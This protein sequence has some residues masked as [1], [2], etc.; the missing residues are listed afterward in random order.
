MFHV[1][2]IQLTRMLFLFQC[3]LPCV[4]ALCNATIPQYGLVSRYL[5]M[6]NQPVQGLV[7]LVSTCEFIVQGLEINMGYFPVWM[8]SNHSNST[9]ATVLTDPISN[10]T[11]ASGEFLSE[12]T[13]LTNVSLD[14][15]SVLLLVDQRLDII[16]G[17]VQL[18]GSDPG[19]P[20]TSLPLCY[21]LAPNYRLRWDIQGSQIDFA[22][23]GQDSPVTWMGFG[24]AAPGVTNRPMGAADA[25]IVISNPPQIID[26]YMSTYLECFEGSGACADSVTT[27]GLNEARGPGRNDST[28]VY[29]QRLGSVNFARFRR[30]LDTGDVGFDHVITP[31]ASQTFVWATGNFLNSSSG[32]K[33]LTHGTDEGTTYGSLT[34][35][36][37]SGNSNCKPFPVPPNAS[38]PVFRNTSGDGFETKFAGGAQAQLA[39]DSVTLFWKLDDVAKV[40]KFGLRCRKPSGYLSLGVGALMSG[41][42]TWVSVV[43][44]DE[45][46]TYN[47]GSQA[48][49][50]FA[51]NNERVSGYAWY[52]K[53]NIY[54]FE[55][56]RPYGE[57]DVSS[58]IPFIWAAG[59]TWHIPPAEEDYHTTRSAVPTYINLRTGTV[60]VAAGDASIVAHGVLMGLA[61]G[62]CVPIAI[63]L[64]RGARLINKHKWQMYHPY[65]NAFAAVLSFIGVIV[66]VALLY[67]NQARHLFSQHA[68]LGLA[69]LVLFAVQIIVALLKPSLTQIRNAGGVV[70]TD[71]LKSMVDKNTAQVD[72]GRSFTFEEVASHCTPQSCWVIIG[73]DVYDLTE[74]LDRHPGGRDVLLKNAGKDVTSLFEQSHESSS[75]ILQSKGK[76]RIGKV[77]ARS[78]SLEEIASHNNQQSCWLAIRGGVYDVTQWLDKHP[79]GRDILLENAGKDATKLFEKE[80]S[81]PDV[82]LQR[83]A[84]MRIGSLTGA[85]APIS[86]ANS[87]S[88]RRRMWYWT[89]LFLG[90]LTVCLS[91][92]TIY[93]GLDLLPTRGF[94]NATSL[95]ALSMAWF[96][97]LSLF[98]GY[99]LFLH[100]WAVPKLEAK[101]G[102]YLA[103]AGCVMLVIVALLLSIIAGVST[104]SLPPAKLSSFV[105]TAMGSPKNI[106]CTGNLSGCSATNCGLIGDGW[107][108]AYAPYNTRECNYD[109]G[110]CCSGTGLFDCLDPT[111]PLFSTSST[112]GFSNQTFLNRR[113]AINSNGQTRQLT[114]SNFATTY[115]NFYEFGFSKNI[116]PNALAQSSIFEGPWNITIDGLVENPITVDVRELVDMMHL[117]ERTYRH[118]CV[119]AWSI[120]VP[121]LGFP[122]YALL[123][124]VKPL[125]SARYVKFTSFRAPSSPSGFPWP[126]VEGLTIDEALNELAFIGVG[127]YGDKL[128]PQSGA[129]IRLIL[130]W[131]YGFKSA[132][133]LVRIELTD[134]RP[135]SFWQEI[136]DQEYGF[137]ANVNPTV[138]HPRWSQA[139]ERP[140]GGS[141]SQASIPTQ[142]YNGYTESVSYLYNHISGEPLFR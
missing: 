113:Y 6:Q 17:S 60:T 92:A 72:E 71:E 62:V 119:E 69:T 117:E 140:L 42:K 38:S 134:T 83:K 106:P 2:F 16:L 128:L 45:L 103:G 22:I 66:I 18:D 85:A 104:Q 13:F 41:A 31:N 8:G 57:M 102:K 111:S 1:C 142:L 101:W 46:Y 61:W 139:N 80:H 112:R 64:M 120:V 52:F 47:M 95:A 124:L 116:Y 131:K 135:L 59:P 10:C 141:A 89:H 28:M 14:Q 19:R 81:S 121:W 43:G 73:G 114:D 40:V 130:P 99:F 138:R 118:R 94:P 7:T 76:L 58:D 67:K 88:Q 37:D 70:Q 9:N 36:L 79:G 23:E 132:K 35:E 98:I 49:S 15:Y 32:L 129:P 63:V 21:Q 4:Q 107:C 82:I 44:S 34:L 125:S 93:D 68:Q 109:G 126:Y 65:L 12:M 86:S 11:G 91:W 115:N 50:S 133:S 51:V 56:A 20:L 136:N 27:Y 30:L 127:A 77:A 75:S 54:S 33:I 84:Q 24:P 96:I 100:K 26:A 53:N 48:A 29:A 122:L 108:D 3:F 5:V 55:F 87:A 110:D 78:Y 74:W 39:D 105:T 25:T 90:L 97:L 123:A 137:W